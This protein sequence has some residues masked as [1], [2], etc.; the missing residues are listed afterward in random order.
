MTLLAIPLVGTQA[1][2]V[3]MG[4][5]ALIFIT[6]VVSVNTWLKLQRLRNRPPPVDPNTIEASHSYRRYLVAAAWAGGSARDWDHSVRPVLADLVE[7]A[8]GAR[9]FKT[10]DARQSAREW[11]GPELFALVDRGARRSEDRSAPGPGRAAMVR[12]LERLDEL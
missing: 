2:L 4:V 8:M 10:G 9:R 12:I 1:G 5:L 3:V 11:L 7:H 6:V